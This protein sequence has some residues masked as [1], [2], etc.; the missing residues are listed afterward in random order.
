MER[1]ETSIKP[2]RILLTEREISERLKELAHRIRTTYARHDRVVVLVVLNGAEH[3]AD[4][5]FSLI[6][7]D[8]FRLSYIKA[9]SYGDRLTSNG[10]VKIKGLDKSALVGEE[11]LIVDDIYDSGLTM[12]RIIDAVGCAG[13]RGIR[14]CVLLAKKAE[15]EREINIDFKAAVVEDCFVVGFG[16]DYG[17]RHRE[18]PFIAKLEITTARMP[19]NT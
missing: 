4:K 17:G 19:G 2:G 8:K 15:R 6:D 14:T 5:L 7:D 13:P 9:S 10:D 12:A 3:F 1:K 18:L 16:L 11:V